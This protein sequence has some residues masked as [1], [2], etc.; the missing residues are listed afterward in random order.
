MEYIFF[1]LVLVALYHFI[2]EAILAPSA[3]L[4]LRF[5]LLA[6]RDTLRNLK[7]PTPTFRTSISTIC[8]IRSTR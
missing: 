3:R 2:L 4:K 7:I 1:A 8:K 6:L 5:E